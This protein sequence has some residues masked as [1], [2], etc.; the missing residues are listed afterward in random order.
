MRTKAAIDVGYGQ[1][2]VVD[3]LEVPD[4]R[5]DQVLV[6]LFSSGI[7]HSQL[8]QMHNSD[9][10][11]PMVLG[12]EGTGVVTHV[13]AN[14]TH[15]K[16]GDHAIVTWVPRTPVRG[17]SAPENSGVTYREEPVHGS[18]YTW[19]EDVLVSG[20]L[21]IPISKDD[22]VD[23]SSI[24]GCAILTGAG[25]VMHTAKVR[26]GNSVAVFG[27]GG[28]GLSAIRMAA[29]LEAYPIIAVDLKDDKLEFAK[30]FGATHVVNGS[31]VNAVEAVVD[32]SGGGVDF[33]F[34]AIGVRATNEQI[35]PST[36][37]GGPGADN[38]GGMAV[39]IGI[40]GDEMTLDPRLFVIH[41]RQFR[42]SLGATY[43]ETDFPMYLR[44]H[45]EGKFPL[46][47]LITRRY[48]LDEINEACD[49][50]HAG[51]I[52]GRAIIEY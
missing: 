11:R 13:G 25:A 34:D 26:P 39:L 35:L 37:G 45:R 44:W 12:H 2:L 33:A 46:D 31:K 23:V 28:V 43:P 14:V 42:G 6:K 40:P 21:V 41:Q 17:R 9:A 36:R 24:V 16:E 51:E 52:M 47:K 32:I 10:P 38:H 22:P 19:G 18:V 27:V 5:P 15:L 49:A 29:I 7:C 8:H 50:L 3:E 30:E 1:R 48:K 4:P 20:E